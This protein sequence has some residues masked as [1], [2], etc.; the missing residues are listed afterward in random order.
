MEHGKSMKPSNDSSEPPEL[1]LPMDRE[2]HALPPCLSLANYC[3]LNRE[4]REM[5][6]KSIPSDEERLARKVSAIFSF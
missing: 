1:D 2:F 3:R 6:P 5:F 4:F